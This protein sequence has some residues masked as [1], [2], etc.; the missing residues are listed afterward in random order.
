[1]YLGLTITRILRRL[2]P[3]E[4]PVPAFLWTFLC[5]A[6]LSYR[7]PYFEHLSRFRPSQPFC[8]N[9]PSPRRVAHFANHCFSGSQRFL[10]V[11]LLKKLHI[12]ATIQSTW[13]GIKMF[14]GTETVI[15][16]LFSKITDSAFMIIEAEI[17]NCGSDILSITVFA[18]E[19]VYDVLWIA[20]GRLTFRAKLFV[21]NATP[22]IRAWV[23]Q[24]TNLT[25]RFVARSY[26]WCR[27]ILNMQLGSN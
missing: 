13:L 27:W 17:G 7:F 10:I 8:I 6:R 1:M 25:S 24:W 11:W 9:A 21:G 26:I 16:T 2:A 5:S 15:I 22:Y 3:F 20:I 18:R 12:Q 19:N 23:N 14:I 4:P